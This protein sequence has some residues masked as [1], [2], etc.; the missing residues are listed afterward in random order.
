MTAFSV[1]KASTIKTAAKA[2][3]KVAVGQ[4][5]RSDV[6]FGVRQASQTIRDGLQTLEL[7]GTGFHPAAAGAFS[8]KNVPLV[9]DLS[10][11][12]ALGPDGVNTPDKLAP[13]TAPA[14]P[15]ASPPKKDPTLFDNA[16]SW[17]KGHPVQTASLS[18]A[19]ALTAL[20]PATNVLFT[21]APDLLS[22]AVGIHPVFAL[23]T[24]WVIN[25]AVLKGLYEVVDTIGQALAKFFKDPP[26][27]TAGVTPR[28]EPNGTTERLEA[29]CATPTPEHTLQG[30]TAAHKTL[31]EVRSLLKQADTLAPEL[32]AK[33]KAKKKQLTMDIEVISRT[34]H[35][36]LTPELAADP[37]LQGSYFI[38]P[39]DN[40]SEE[41]TKKL[42][43]SKNGAP[44]LPGRV[45]GRGGMG[46]VY[47]AIDAETGELAAVKLLLDSENE[48]RFNREYINMKKINNIPGVVRAIGKG[49]TKVADVNYSYLVMEYMA[50][51]T[52]DLLAAQ[53]DLTASQ[54]YAITESAAGTMALAHG[55]GVIHRDLKAENIFATEDRTGAKIPDWGLSMSVNQEHLTQEGFL[56]GSAQSLSPWRIGAFFDSRMLDD[57]LDK[58]DD[59][60]GLGTAFYKAF[61]GYNPILR[62]AQGKMYFVGRKDVLGADGAIIAKALSADSFITSV[63]AAY[64]EYKKNLAAGNAA[65]AEKYRLTLVTNFGDLRDNRGAIFSNFVGEVRNMPGDVRLIC[66]QAMPFTEAEGYPSASR[67]KTDLM[68]LRDGQSVP[69]LS[70]K[71]DDKQ[72]DSGRESFA[73]DSNGQDGH[74]TQ[75][76]K[77]RPVEPKAEPAP[78]PDIKNLEGAL[79]YLH[80]VSQRLGRVAS[81]LDTITKEEIKVFSGNLIGIL[82]EHADKPFVQRQVWVIQATISELIN[83]GEIK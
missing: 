52:L 54:T 49:I 41:M 68:L 55:E 10:L 30:L 71:R 45:L 35:L 14:T 67:M 6:R 33:F 61:S 1:N 65:E 66:E 51:Q 8:A 44:K 21:V 38:L 32:Q 46:E 81:G 36:V 19:G 48:E 58:K 62:D 74:Q 25:M 83:K 2:F 80:Q 82:R 42:A 12:A 28:T 70:P 5:L 63:G 16:A 72:P 13:A 53:K 43:G 18:A 15:P 3:W 64:K 37:A 56:I 7:S 11:T 69:P 34:F 59:I 29:L 73:D 78:V 76:D 75:E 47:A 60:Y 4:Q 40:Q 77:T 31:N 23:I 39:P 17:L 24:S 27:K 57:S 79:D 20:L 9:R 26:E 22:G 50:G